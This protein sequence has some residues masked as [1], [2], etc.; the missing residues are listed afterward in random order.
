MANAPHINRAL[1][2]SEVAQK[3]GELA[4][5]NAHYTHRLAAMIQNEH[6]V[7]V[8]DITVGQLLDAIDTLDTQFMLAYG[9]AS[10]L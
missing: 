6:Q 8:E 9:N 10:G 7:P 3:I 4:E 1:A 5:T 2:I